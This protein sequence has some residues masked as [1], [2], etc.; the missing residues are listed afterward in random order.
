MLLGEYTAAASASEKT[1]GKV[2]KKHATTTNGET[3]LTD[4]TQSQSAS[5]SSSSSFPNFIYTHNGRPLAEDLTVDEVGVE[6][7]DTIVAVEMVD[8]TES[9][10]S[11]HSLS[12]APRPFVR[13]RL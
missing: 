5:S 4:K 12:V 3:P 8:L 13:F 9:V 10:V 7:G 1:N 2:A 11:P 6:D